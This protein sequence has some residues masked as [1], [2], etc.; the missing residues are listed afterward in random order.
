METKSYL[1]TSS[2]PIS[3]YAEPSTSCSSYI[4]GMFDGFSGDRLGAGNWFNIRGTGITARGNGGFSACCEVRELVS[5]IKN[6]S[7]IRKK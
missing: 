6:K 1:K 5:H 2:T 4:Q 3:T 7:N